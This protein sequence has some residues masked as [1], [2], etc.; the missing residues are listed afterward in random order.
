[1]PT[2]GDALIRDLHARLAAAADPERA[3]QMQAYMKSQMPFHG[4]ASP[5]MK[6]LTRECF[7]E[8]PLDESDW[9]ATAATLWEEAEHREERYAALALIRLS[10]HRSAARSP[11]RLP[12]YRH[13][14]TTGAW[15]DLVDEIAQHLVGEVLRTHRA[16]ATPMVRKWADDQDLWVR[17]TAILS[18]NRHRAE[19]DVDLLDQV[20]SANLEDSLHGRVFWTRKAV[21]WAL[22][23]FAKTD[24]TWVRGWVTAH[25][26]LLSGLTRREALKHF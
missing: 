25:D 11:E 8:H 17:R 22:R 23:E 7:A 26:D 24:P 19:T 10:T 4:I 16:E 9:L 12:L 20:L 15:W 6:R 5:V 21:G 18:Q 2:P 3:P 13:L 14:A 1:M